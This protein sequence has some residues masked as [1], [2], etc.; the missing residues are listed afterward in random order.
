MLKGG[1]MWPEGEGRGC[2]GLLEHSWVV[3][4]V[5]CECSGADVTDSHHRYCFDCYCWH[6]EVTEVSVGSCEDGSTC[7]TGT[8]NVNAEETEAVTEASGEGGS[9]VA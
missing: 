4:E 3:V 6:V 2:D 9:V 5:L 7:E 8:S 1:T